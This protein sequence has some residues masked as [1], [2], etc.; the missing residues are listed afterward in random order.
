MPQELYTKPIICKCKNGEWFV[1]FRYWNADT[2]QWQPIKRSNNLNRI[3]DLEEKEAE[4]EAFREARENWLKAGWNPITDTFPSPV[5]QSMD[6]ENLRKMNLIEGMQYG[7]NEKKNDW[8]K[9]TIETYEPMFNY[10]KRGSI[11][12]ETNN[13]R[14]SFLNSLHCK[15][16]LETTCELRK[17]GAKGFNKYKDFLSSIIGYLSTHEIIKDNPVEKIRAKK[18]V[19][20]IAHRPPTDDERKIIVDTMQNKH[21][22]YFRFLAVEYGCTMRPAEIC[23]LR[24][25]NLHKLQQEFR[26]IPEDH[27]LAPEEQSNTKTDIERE[28]AIPYW[29]MDLLM[30]MNL[31][32]YDPEC[33]IF[34]MTN[35]GGKFLPGPKRMS[36]RTST[37]WWRNIV[38]APREE[39]GLNINV[40]QY[41]LKKLSGDDMIKLQRK[42]GINNLLDLPRQQMG[43]TKS[44]QT[45]IYVNEHKNVLKD[46]IKNKM[47]A[48]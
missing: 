40:D 34:T 47:P 16:L 38:K 45:E 35:P 22:N 3:H 13:I 12:S 41:S 6:L 32:N 9:R 25:K 2:N 30:E 7:Y 14:L 18:T 37:T 33:F 4:F 15:K 43:H 21:R 5:I 10:L 36:P 48:L 39:G 26:L 28:V 31:Q 20:T 27:R 44:A 19:K 24:I 23:G 46:V 17:L 29:L 1:L 11:V 42:E 8:K